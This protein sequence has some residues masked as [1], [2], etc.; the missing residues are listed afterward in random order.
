VKRETIFSPC[1]KYRYTLWRDFHD[2]D[3]SFNTHPN[4]LGFVQFIGLNP[5]IADETADDPTIRRCIQFAKSWGYGAMVMTNLF[6]FRATEPNVMKA[7]DCPETPDL[8]LTNRIHI[9]RLAREAKIVIAAWGT[10]GSHM[11]LGADTILCFKQNSIPL[12]HLGLNTDGTPKHPLYLR[13]DTKPVLFN[14]QP[15]GSR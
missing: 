14:S 1:R 11:G 12:Y 6:A 9:L 8:S 3:F 7:S 4:A 2:G 5:S 13:A 10:H 15:G